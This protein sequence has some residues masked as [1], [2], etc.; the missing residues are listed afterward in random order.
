MK[1]G[2]VASLDKKLLRDL[3]RIKG[4]VMAIAAV[5][6]GGVALF[7]LMLGTLQSLE[8]TRDAYYERYRFAHVFAEARRVPQSSLVEIAGIAGVQVAEGRV[9]AN[10]TLDIATLSEPATGRLISIP[11]EG[12]PALNQLAVVAGTLPDPGDPLAAVVSE[13][14]AEAHGLQPGDTVATVMNERRRVLTISG[15]GL[16]PEYVYSIG[17]GALFPDDRTFGVFWVR[18]PALASAFDMEGAF[19]S[20]TVALLRGTQPEPVIAAIDR[21]LEPYGGIGA[22]GRAD[23]TSHWFLANELEQLGV[24][25]RVLPPIFLVV[26]AFLLNIAVARLIET[27]R[28]QIGLLKAFGYSDMEVGWHYAKMS[29]AMAA[30]GVAAGCLLGAWMGRGM[31]EIYA[32]F[33][34]FPFLQYRPAPAI[35]VLAAA[36]GAAA[37]LVGTLTAVRRAVVL[38]PAEAMRP[39]A[40]AKFSRGPFDRAQLT[41]WLT[42]TDRI[43]LRNIRRWPGRSALTATGTAVAAAI[44][45][46]AMFA[47]GAIEHMMDVQF[48]RAQRQDATITFV[49]PRPESV[50]P[51]IRRLPG[52]ID[53]EPFRSVP[54]NLRAGIRRERTSITGLDAD[55]NLFRLLD[56][57]LEPI[58][59][60]PYGLML[61]ASVAENLAVG[62]GDT[63]TI[64]VMEGRRPTLTA[65]VTAIAEEYIGGSVVMRRDALARLMNE[66]PRL[67]GAYIALDSAFEGPFHDRLK[68]TPAI[69]AIS[70]KSRIIESFR[71]QVTDTFYQTLIINSLFGGLIAFGVVYNSARIMVSERSRELASLRVLGFTRF[72]I[73]YILLGELALLTAIG[74][75]LGCLMGWGMA[76]SL[77]GA[78][79]TDLYRIPLIVEP[80]TYGLALSVVGGAALISGL[81]VARRLGKLDLVA[82]LKARE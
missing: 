57:E 39:P 31:T 47:L 6:A 74:L 49:N 4:Q 28:E 38:P 22:I 75:P 58:S 76:A 73:T 52:V 27:E 11:D 2:I 61:A 32:A 66:S 34:R 64:E 55:N 54:V 10:V 19:N 24:T 23:Q 18:R 42:Q 62:R 21:I 81:I 40:P 63:V 20:L 80:W 14:F 5:L 82:V 60:P 29:L 56:T 37:A 35:F 68:E 72:E 69:A 78:F 12:Q 8:Q 17:P 46:G 7:V 26:A 77:A 25:V 59:V 53:V 33:F 36:I 79:E 48:N 44:M 41:A 50:I 16:S 70:M 9:S 43:I 1:A 13:G 71:T 3:W 51:E 65:T 45:I 30:V 15:I 67:S